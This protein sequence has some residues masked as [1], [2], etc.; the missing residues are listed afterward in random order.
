M[1]WNK[2]LMHFDL[3]IQQHDDGSIKNHSTKQRILEIIRNC[4]ET[5]KDY[6]KDNKNNNKEKSK[7]NNITDIK[8]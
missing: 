8:Q 6:F 3:I 2:Y 4:D 1:V 5:V 7:T